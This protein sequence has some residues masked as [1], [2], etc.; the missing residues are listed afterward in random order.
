MYKA[1]ATRTKG[2]RREVL[3]SESINPINV[4]ELKIFLQQKS[5]EFDETVKVRVIEE[6]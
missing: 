3:V 5:E 4:A 1:Y 6:K 2:D